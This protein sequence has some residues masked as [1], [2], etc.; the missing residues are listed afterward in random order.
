MD[1]LTG[2]DGM[3]TSPVRLERL[4][5]KTDPS[6]TAQVNIVTEPVLYM[7]HIYRQDKHAVTPLSE[8]GNMVVED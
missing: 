4:E 3:R 6:S 8:A 7:G 5:E 1:T 2:S